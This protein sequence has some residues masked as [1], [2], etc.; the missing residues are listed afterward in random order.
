MAEIL[1]KR[2]EKLEAIKPSDENPRRIMETRMAALRRAIVA[3]PEMLELRPVIVNEHGE[4]VAGEMRWRAAGLEGHA[5]VPVAWVKFE[6]RAEEREWRLRDNNGYGEWVE[7]ELA[8]MLYE[9]EQDGRDLELTGFSKED[10]TKLLDTVAGADRKHNWPDDPAPSPPA[11]PSS[12]AGRI[13]KLGPHRLMCGDATNAKHVAKLLDGAKPRLCVTDPPY[14]VDLDLEWRDEAGLGAKDRGNSKTRSNA[15]MKGDAR[16]DWSEVF[17]LVPSL[18]VVYHWHASAFCAEVALG[19]KRINYV[20]AQLIIWDK[21]AF[22]LS[23]SHYHW[24]HEAAF[25]AINRGDDAETEVPWYGPIADT[26]WYARKKGTHLP[27]LGARDQ[28]TVWQAPSPKMRKGKDDDE[29]VDHPTQKPVLLYQRP[30]Q[31]HLLRGEAL[32]EPFAGSGTAIVAAEMTGRVCYAMEIDP[33]FCDVTRER[34]KR[35]TGAGE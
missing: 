33:A 27:W 15:K 4:I 14:G 16:S 19:L 28:T 7:Q 10:T 3:S 34:Y 21:M 25:Y 12:R 6:S 11:N 24:Q 23:R 1:R 35:Y 17:E 26:A 8:Q 9:L 30:I 20:T 18:A 31:N 2:T 13:Y 5:T 29:T 32:Y 22:A